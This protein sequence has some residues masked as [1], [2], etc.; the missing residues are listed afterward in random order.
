M[1]DVNESKLLL[2][3]E[4]EGKKSILGDHVIEHF[5]HTKEDQSSVKEKPNRIEGSPACAPQVH[6]IQR[7]LLCFLHKFQSYH[8]W[9]SNNQSTNQHLPLKPVAR[10][11]SFFTAHFFLN[12]PRKSRISTLST[13]KWDFCNKKREDDWMKNAKQ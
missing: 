5:G 10:A 13:L 6:R 3:V 7:L 9:N 4:N 1:C 2:G 12:K 11:F 8:C